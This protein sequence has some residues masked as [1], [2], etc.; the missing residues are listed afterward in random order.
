M[1]LPGTIHLGHRKLKV[2]EISPKTASKESVYGDF[3]PA[4]DRIRIDRSLTHTKKLNTLIHEI[5]HLL[6]DHFN[7]GLKDKDEEKVCE[8]LGSG[9]SD[10]FAQNPR[11]LK[12]INS[13]YSNNKK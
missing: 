6:L 10:L 12:Y 5:V 8:V 11:L 9:L 13:V 7:A 4:K 1:K 3:D 2:S